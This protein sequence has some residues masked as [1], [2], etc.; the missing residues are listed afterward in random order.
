MVTDGYKLQS[1]VSEL[2][3]AKVREQ[4]GNNV[5][6]VLDAFPNQQY[7]GK[8]VSVDA[9]E[10][11]KTE[12]KYYRVNII[13]DAAGANLRAGMSADAT[14][15]SAMKKGVLRVPELA[16]YT[17]DRSKYVKVLLPGLDKA[18]SEDSLGRVPIKTG[19]TDGDFVE[20]TGGDLR[21]GQIVA[22]SAE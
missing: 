17:D 22:V 1:D 7:D 19:I 20:I 2:D 15:L 9:Q 21:E 12:D 16:V 5:R 3:I 8:V 18:V 10:I 13:F 11:I 4:D 14:I 6:I